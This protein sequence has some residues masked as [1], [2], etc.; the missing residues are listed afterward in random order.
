[1][2]L[3]DLHTQHLVISKVDL[4]TLPMRDKYNAICDIVHDKV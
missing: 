1:M 2:D 3:I 4:V